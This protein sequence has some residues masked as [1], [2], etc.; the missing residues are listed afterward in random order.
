M[1]LKHLGQQSGDPVDVLDRI[2]WEGGPI[3]VALD[4]SEF[5]SHCP[6][7]RQPDFGELLIEYVPDEWLAETK[8]VKLYLWRFRELAQYNERLVEGI[9]SD[10][11]AQLEPLALRVVGSFHPRGGI[12]VTATATRGDREAM[13]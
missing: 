3:L 9:A 7:T 5:T 4:C 2:P 13:E 10:I 12:S 8:S 6:V 11:F 1:A